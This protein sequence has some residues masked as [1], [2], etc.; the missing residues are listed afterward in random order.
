MVLWRVMC[1]DLYMEEI[2]GRLESKAR[3]IQLLNG[4]DG[5]EYG[6]FDSDS[7]VERT[8]KALRRTEIRSCLPL[9]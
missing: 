5:R 9:M 4:T 8:V 2:K 3:I 6:Y 1:L 7:S